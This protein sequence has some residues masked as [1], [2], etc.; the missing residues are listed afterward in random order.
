[1]GVDEMK[2]HWE[3]SEME[4]KCPV[5]GH[6]PLEEEVDEQGMVHG[7]RCPMGCYIYNYDTEKMKVFRIKKR[8]MEKK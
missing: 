5:C 1:M 4:D 6:T 8:E 3:K 7:E 2:R